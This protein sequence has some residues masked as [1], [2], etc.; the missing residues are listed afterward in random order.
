MLDRS[1]CN[2]MKERE[3]TPLTL[4]ELYEEVNAVKSAVS[5]S[6]I[7]SFRNLEDTVKRYQEKTHD[8]DHEDRMASL[9]LLKCCLRPSAEQGFCPRE[10]L[11]H[12]FT[13]MAHLIREMET[14]SDSSATDTATPTQGEPGAAIRLPVVSEPGVVDSLVEVDIPTDKAAASISSKDS[15]AAAIRP[16][17]AGDVKT[18]PDGTCW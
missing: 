12:R 9:N 5:K 14:K 2:L 16:V 18:G 3:G 13:T 6:F 4:E 10:A 15:D 1:L 7:H 17:D 8:L 11:K